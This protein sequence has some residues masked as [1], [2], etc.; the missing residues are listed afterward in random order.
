MAVLSQPWEKCLTRETPQPYSA[1][2][3]TVW[4]VKRQKLHRQR[5]RMGFKLLARA[6]VGIIE[7]DAVMGKRHDPRGR[8]LAKGC[9]E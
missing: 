6:D 1:V 4:H 3:S 5:V 2:S 8:S 9:S 7:M